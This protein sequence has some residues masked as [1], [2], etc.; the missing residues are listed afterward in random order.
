[1]RLA[2]ALVVRSC[3]ASK[4]SGCGKAEACWHAASRSRT[5]M[6]RGSMFF[7]CPLRPQAPCVLAAVPTSPTRAY[8]QASGIQ[9]NSCL[10]KAVRTSAHVLDNPTMGRPHLLITRDTFGCS[11]LFCHLS[12]SPQA[13][14]IG[15]PE[16]LNHQQINNACSPDLLGNH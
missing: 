6:S 1:M 15:A 2:G 4:G 11:M 10:V 13:A 16:R 7:A 3:G 8:P 14:S 5:A 12:H 9:S